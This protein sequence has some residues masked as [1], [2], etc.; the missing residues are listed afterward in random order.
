MQRLEET[1]NRL[2]ALERTVIS[3]VPKAA[4]EAMENFKSYVVFR[5]PEE[6]HKEHVIIQDPWRRNEEIEGPCR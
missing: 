1:A 2:L 6:Y 3:G 5:S 4:E